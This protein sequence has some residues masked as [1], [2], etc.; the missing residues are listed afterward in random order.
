MKQDAI[1][2]FYQNEGLDEFR[3]SG[4]RLAFLAREVSRTLRGTPGA[5]V[6]DVGVGSGLFEALALRSGL[7]VHAIDPSERA[8]ASVGERLGLGEKARAGYVQAIPFPDSHFRA[9]VASEVFEHLDD[10]TLSAGL[11]EIRRVLAPGSC[12][13]GTVPAREDLGRSLVVCPDCGKRFHRW[14]H[15]QSF[16]PA[17]LR[18]L[19]E[20]AFE[21]ERIEERPFPPWRIL[22]WKGKLLDA[23]KVALWRLGIHGSLEWVYFRAR[24]RAERG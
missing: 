16:D 13:F 15:V 22:N 12:L 1:W 3:G 6:L 23:T 20:S 8:I 9:V 19:F 5:R 11:A 2:D 18:S 7:D 21:P 4:T 17:R 24:K 10:S 14:G